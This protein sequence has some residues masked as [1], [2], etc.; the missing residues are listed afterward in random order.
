MLR[1]SSSSVVMPSPL[2][3]V[4]LPVYNRATW[5][6]RAID[7]VLAQSYRNFEL[8]VVDDGSTDDTRAVLDRYRDRITIVTQ[9]NRGAYVARNHALRIARGELIAF[10][11]SDDAWLPN[12]LADQIPLFARPT[13]GLVFGDAVHMS[14]DLELTKRT[15]FLV[16]PPRRG[17]VAAEFAR[18]NFVPTTTVTV[19]RSCLDEAGGFSEQNALS[20]DYLMWFRIA[21]RH[22]IDYVDHVVA[23]YTVHPAGISY[24]LGRSLRARIELF[25]DE[26][27]RT[28]DTDARR[29]LRRLLMNLSLRLVVATVR[30]RARTV[31]DPLAF[32]RKTAMSVA[33]ADTAMS[34]AKLT[35]HEVRA[36]TRRLFS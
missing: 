17:R 11:D 18:A 25:S 23:H 27:E 6:A 10:I 29:I 7:S 16:S 12:R 19:R 26:L 13:V 33:S 24:D 4:I 9:E 30:G 35:A 5:I 8:I 2:V 3:S 21:L 28:S 34:A 20:A 32:A 14:A 1:L 22:D 15:C 36:R 31:S